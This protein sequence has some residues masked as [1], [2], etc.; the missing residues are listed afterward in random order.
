MRVHHLNCATLCP[1]A[2]SLIVEKGQPVRGMVSHVLAIETGDGLVLVDTGFGT[3]DIEN[4]ARLGAG[5]SAFV[6]PRLDREETALAQ[7]KKLGFTAADVRH[8]VPTHLDLDHAG[9]LPDFPEAKV[10]VFGP[11]L[12]AVL[13]RATHKEK[14]RYRPAHFAHGPRWV[15]YAVQGERWNG[16]EAVRDL[17][18]LPPEILLVPTIGHTR[19]HVAVAVKDD[20]GW[21]LHC[22]DA[23]FHHAEMDPER[24][25]C[26]IGLRIFQGTIA[27]DDVARRRNSERLRL[28]ARDEAVRVFSAHDPVE[29]DRMRGA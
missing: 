3:G 5:F 18:G 12:D 10:H 6:R 8:I 1:V 26:P 11:E 15:R 13:K 21:M 17:Q 23:Y 9:G 20:A 16:F 22:G 25:R 2:A 4:P 29:L 14:S 28:L 24:P 19:G 7:V 27:M